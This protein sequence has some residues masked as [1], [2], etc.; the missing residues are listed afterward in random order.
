MKLSQRSS[1]Q[2]YSNS[3]NARTLSALLLLALFSAA[4]GLCAGSS[5]LNLVGA[6][7]ELFTGNARS[8]DA[9]ILLYVRLPRVCASLLA[10]AALAVSGVLLQAVLGN[11]LASPNVIGVNAGA[12]FFTFLAMALLPGRIAA[13]PTGAFLGALLAALLVY[14]VAAKAGAGKLTIILAGVAV[15]SVFTAGINTIKTFFPDTLYNGST[16]LIGGFSG[17]SLKDLSPAWALILAGLGA[18]LLFGRQVDVLCL[19]DETAQSLGMNVT[20]TRFILIFIACVLAGCAVSFSGLISFVG[21]IVPHICRRLVGT[22]H[23]AL[24][25]ASCLMGAGF[26]SLC[27]LFSRVLFAPYEIP[28]GIL[29]SFLGGPFFLFLILRQ[30]G[31]RPRQKK[32]PK[33]AGKHGP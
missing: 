23:K 14:A 27:D 20:L 15:S 33:A 17:V 24:L 8:P 4:L 25:L 10:G 18:S 1:T 5:Q 7:R 2:L 6:L 3:K 16:F 32:T 9:R 11:P 29:L 28:V 13:A 19:G 21:L 26:V 12:G 30:R 31:S 22:G